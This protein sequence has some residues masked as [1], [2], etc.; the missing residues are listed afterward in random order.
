M[1]NKESDQ[2]RAR[3]FKHVDHSMALIRRRDHFAESEPR[4]YGYFD[5]DDVKEGEI[6]LAAAF[7]GIGSLPMPV[8]NI[9]VKA[10]AL[11][12]FEKLSVAQAE[13]I[14]V[15]RRHGDHQWGAIVGNYLT[16]DLLQDKGMGMRDSMG[17]VLLN[18]VAIVLRRI[19]VD[20]A[21]GDVAARREAEAKAA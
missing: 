18:P 12:R 17:N 9:T 8:M 19:L 20:R 7:L 11:M 3:V 21:V 14:A 16:A 6:I 5:A 4:Y 1:N 15:A 2:L 13:R 10:E